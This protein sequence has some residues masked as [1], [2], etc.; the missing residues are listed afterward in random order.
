MAGRKP[1]R[2]E[3]INTILKAYVDAD[4]REEPIPI[5]QF[6]SD[7]EYLGRVT[8]NGKTV[9]PY[10]KSILS[11]IAIDDSRF[12]TV[13][14]G[15]IGTGK[16]RTAV[17]AICY[18]M[19]KVLCLKD[20]WEFYG[21]QAGGKIAVVF[22]NLTKSLSQGKGYNILQSYLLSSPWFNRHGIIMNEKGANP[23][24]EFPVF[25]FKSGSPYAKGFG[26]VGE[27]VLFAIMDEVDSEMES[28]KQKIR[29][30]KA[31]E[32]AVSRLES[33]FV[34]IAKYSGKRET[35][36]RFFLCASKQEKASFLNTFIVK[37]KNS[38]IIRI[39][40][41]AL[42]EVKT[43][44]NFS[45]ETFPIMLGDLYTP[46]KILC[47][48]TERGLEIDQVG[49]DKAVVDGFDIIQVP[50]ELL[51]RFQKD[52]VGNLRRLAGVSVNYLR[53]SKLFPSEKHLVD[54]Y[55]PAKRDPVPM[56]TIEVGVNDNID[57]A[58]YIDFS[59]IRIPRHVPRYI[60]V[61]I[62]YSGNGDAL[63]LGMSCVS[64]WSD[65]VIEDLKEGGNMKIVKLPIIETDFGMRIKARPNDEINLSS[66]R[67]LIADLKIVYKFNIRLA[68]YD[69]DAL[70]KESQQILNR[71]GIKSEHLSLDRDPSIYRGFRNLVVDKRWCCHRDE[72]LHFELVN[73]E[74]DKEKNK[75]DHPDEVIDIEILEDGSTQDVV[76]K[77]SKDESDGVVGSVENALRNCGDV[78]SKDFTTK[79]K[80]SF[81]VQDKAR[82]IG[83]L[84]S[85]NKTLV[86]DP[87]RQED[88]KGTDVDF[89]NIF[90]KSQ[91]RKL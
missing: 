59:A 45:G 17:A 76:V 81:P 71:I 2:L 20:P 23:R 1:N 58:K 44:L 64:G 70:S 82:T 34:R 38:P 68:T 73:L 49:M 52:L 3:R 7:P 83:S 47:I 29:V 87:K 36:G 51:E 54:C 14:T 11:D 91:R 65:R 56:H 35:L 42:W 80:G 27:D 13:L 33:R 39:V 63:G 84:L 66:V 6:L 77:G 16:T 12:L 90:D 62:A 41:A 40:D 89:K 53:K 31:Y 25:E 60:H 37:M 10:W 22:F 9:Y 19:Y 15:A 18:G 57:L 50:V 78:P 72:Y 67:K 32:E 28:D 30:L 75:I 43:D 61:D 24:I 86:G 4:Y 8:G 26:F 88:P 5:G 85:I 74:D 46:S 48:E 55:D 21:K 69:Y 79:V